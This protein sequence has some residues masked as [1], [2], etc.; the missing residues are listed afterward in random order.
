MILLGWWRRR[1]Q[2]AR[3]DL[4]VRASFYL[5]FALIP[6]LA[7]IG[8]S[9]Q[10][11]A[12]SWVVLPFITVHT[13]L[14]VLVV[15]A[16]LNS[17]LGRRPRPTMLV[18]AVIALTAAGTAGAYLA[19]PEVPPGALDGVATGILTVLAGCCV[20][21]ISAAVRL[22]VTAA[23]AVAFCAAAYAISVAQ[24]DPALDSIIVYGNLLA[25]VAIAGRLSTWMLGVVWELDRARQ[26]QASLA[27][28]EERLRFARDLHD[29]AG[30]TLSVIALKA[31]LAAQLARRGQ[32]TAIDE[33][34]EVRQVAEDSLA[35]L[36]AVVGG[37]RSASLDVEL[38]GAR[39]LLASA[40]IACRMIG[41]GSGL[42][43]PLQT[44]LGWAVR[45]GATN[46]LRHSDA[47][48]CTIALRCDPTG[49]VTLRMDNDGVRGEPGPGGRVRFGGGLV[50]LAERI[51]GLGGTVTADRRADTFCL[52]VELPPAAEPQPVLA[53]QPGGDGDGTA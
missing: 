41:D 27:V 38:A 3:I 39:S 48:E 18:V 21:A 25:V 46:V 42:S 2:A 12:A 35:E 28:A 52:A 22:R 50:G 26:V 19:F 13:L 30:R 53:R 16:G 6:V 44:T 5:N 1:S 7:A 29:V 37:Y 8:L 45:E 43:A 15:R 49:T 24:G 40:G 31:E 11:G 9:P 51:A 34:L 17:Y 32:D 36:R 20:A 14:C 47:R 23:V 33:M 4:F 10:L